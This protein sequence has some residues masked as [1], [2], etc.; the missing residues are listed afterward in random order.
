MGLLLESCIVRVAFSLLKLHPGNH[1][2]NTF[3]YVQTVWLFERNTLQVCY[4]LV[5]AVHL[6]LGTGLLGRLSLCC[7]YPCRLA[8]LAS[9]QSHQTK[10]LSVNELLILPS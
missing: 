6:D 4:H 9:K 8:R 3:R 1:L 5:I 2:A 10:T 7:Y